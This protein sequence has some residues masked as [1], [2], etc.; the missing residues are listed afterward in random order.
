[1]PAVRRYFSNTTSRRATHAILNPQQ[2]EDGNDMM[3]EI[4]PRAAKVS[5][6]PGANT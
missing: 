1:M 3:L 4:T 6:H 2:D 5:T